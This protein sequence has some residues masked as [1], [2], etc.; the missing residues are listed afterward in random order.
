MKQ[1]PIQCITYRPAIAEGF[2]L[3]VEHGLIASFNMLE[4]VIA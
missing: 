1:S 2:P 3:T 4:V